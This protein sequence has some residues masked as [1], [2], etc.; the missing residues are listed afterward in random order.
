EV[1]PLPHT[2][3]LDPADTTDAL[4][5]I[6]LS[7]ARLFVLFWGDEQADPAH[8]VENWLNRHTF[9]AGDSWYGQVRRATYA[10]AAPAAAPA[11]TL[12]ARFG[13]H[14]TLQGYSLQSAALQPGDILQLTLF[15]QSDAALDT[16]YKVFVHLY[17]DPNQPPVAQ[18]DG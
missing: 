6:A 8:V 10:V 18:Q 7:H 14:I 2:R 5:R 13:D 11:V 12:G 4:A 9:K 15:W 3:P 17:A 1:Y 16:R